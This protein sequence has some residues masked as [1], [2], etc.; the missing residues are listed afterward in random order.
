MRDQSDHHFE[1]RRRNSR[2]KP[3]AGLETAAEADEGGARPPGCRGARWTPS[4]QPA[5]DFAAAA[6]EH[7]AVSGPSRQPTEDDLVLSRSGLARR[8]RIRVRR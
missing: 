7:I 4:R 1:A 5:A 3:R 6:A 2:L 8:I